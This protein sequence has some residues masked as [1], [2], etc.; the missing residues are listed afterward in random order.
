MERIMDYYSYIK[1][2]R[3]RENP[4]RLAE[5]QAADY[6]CR[7][8]YASRHDAQLEVHHR[9]YVRLGSEQVGDLITLCKDCHHVVTDMLRR[10]RYCHLHPLVADVIPAFDD[11][12]SIFDVT[13]S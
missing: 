12:D 9:T 5:L 13:R 6:R 8:C 7:L 1:S 11:E 2:S 3:W 4:A 10:R